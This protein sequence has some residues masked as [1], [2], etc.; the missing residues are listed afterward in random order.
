VPRRRSG[1]YP[2]PYTAVIEVDGA[3]YLLVDRTKRGFRG[4]R[5]TA[6]ETKMARE[7]FDD[8]HADVEARLVGSRGR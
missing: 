2:S 3:M 5:L 6:T 4:V 8:A 1:S 7:A